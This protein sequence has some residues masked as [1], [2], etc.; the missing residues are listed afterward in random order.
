M[1]FSDINSFDGNNKRHIYI[2][3]R[4][5]SMAAMFFRTLI[6]FTTLIVLMRLLGKRQMGEME[7][8]ELMVSVL[9][10]DIASMPLQDVNI[11]LLYGLMPCVVLFCCELILSGVALES[12]KLRRILCGKPCLLVD[13]GTIC[14]REMNACRFTVSELTEALR[15]QSVMDISTVQYAVLETNGSV[16]VVLKPEYQPVTAEQM[17]IVSEY[18]PYPIILIEEGELLKDN[19][20]AVGRDERWLAKLLKE[21]GASSVKDVYVLIYHK[22]KLFFELRAKKDA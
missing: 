12:V 19:L 7:L 20:R 22:D 2:C 10:A 5:D 14:Q 17:G 16:S 18:K 3:E 8:S 6:I 11:P 1:L 21:K 15:A 13:N 9:I 4:D